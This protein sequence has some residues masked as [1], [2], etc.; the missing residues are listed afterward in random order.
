MNYFCC[1]RFRIYEQHLSRILFRRSRFWIG[2]YS[3]VTTKLIEKQLQKK[4]IFKVRGSESINKILEK[5]LGRN[6][7]FR[8]MLC[9]YE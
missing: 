5:Y 8:N 6:L 2:S 7:H 3:E 1:R 9:I 4:S